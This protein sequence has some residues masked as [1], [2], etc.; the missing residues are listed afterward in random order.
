MYGSGNYCC[1]GRP[2]AM[3]LLKCEVGECSCWD[4]CCD[5]GV[6]CGVG[7]MMLGI[8][9]TVRLIGK[10]GKYESTLSPC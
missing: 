10:G 4:G 2:L 1:K 8:G 7:G 3:D 6:N 5:G 9:W